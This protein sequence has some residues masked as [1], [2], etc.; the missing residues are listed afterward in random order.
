MKTLTI[1]EQLQTIGLSKDQSTVYLYLIHNGQMPA[2]L[3]SRRLGIG[4]TLMYKVLDDLIALSLATKDDSFKVTRY[5]ASHPYSL[6]TIADENKKTA[7]ELGRK[8][9]SVLGPLVSEFNL[10]SQKPAIHF[11][12]GLEGVS[13]VLEDSLTSSEVIYMYVDNETLEQELIDIDAQ[14]VK[15]RLKKKIEKNILMARTPD[16]VKYALNNQTELTK[17][18]LISSEKIPNFYSFMYIYDKKV[19]YVTYRKK[20]FT[21][22]II[23]DESLYTMQRFV[24]EA[25]WQKVVAE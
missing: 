6:R 13:F 19:S 7:D 21:S 12:E 1:E 5:S 18:R 8:I 24:F 2:N 10:Q 9:E 14:Y 23:Y 22:A 11:M 20:V 4:R 25:L 15:E 3:L 17:T 16:S